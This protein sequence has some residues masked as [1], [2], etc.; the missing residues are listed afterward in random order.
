MIDLSQNPFY[1]SPD[2]IK[3]VNETKNS[4]SLEEKVG[5]LF[6]VAA[7]IPDKEMIEK[8]ISGIKPGGIMFRPLPGNQVREL[9]ELVNSISTVPMLVA[10]NLEDGASGIS[11]D[12]VRFGNNMQVAATGD[13]EFA[14]KQGI[15][16]GTQGASVGCNWSFSPVVDLNINHKNPITNTRSYGDKTEVV[17]EMSCSFVKGIQESGIAATIKHFPGDGVDDRDHH[18]LTSCNNLTKEQW[19]KTYGEVYKSLIKVGTKAVMAGHISL[20]CYQS[21]VLPATL[22]S[23]LLVDLLR[24]QLGFNGV[25]VTDATLM[26]GFAVEERAKTVPKSIAAGCDMFLFTRNP[27]EDFNAMMMGVMEGVI[28]Q[29]RLDEAVTRVLALKASQKLYVNEKVLIPDNE[30]INHWHKACVDKAVTLLKD[31]QGVIPL[32]PKVTQKIQ[33]RKLYNAEVP[34]SEQAVES[35]REKLISK[36]FQ[37]GILDGEKAS[38]MLMFQSV[39]EF[40]SQYDM[41]IYI[42]DLAPKSNRTTLRFS[43]GSQYGVDFPVM[44]HEIPMISVNFGSPYVL[45]DLPMMKTVINAYGNQESTIEAVVNKLVGI[46]EFTGLS[47]VEAI[48]E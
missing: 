39:E 33:L 7:A 8:F 9:T 47:P 22:S 32:N 11:E 24:N 28:S 26:V 4:L 19:D 16:A 6:C 29:Q 42:S 3:W 46:G 43:Y 25:I 18:L 13:S 41:V 35:F 30:K 48:F 10:A 37:V 17:K 36:G 23:E 45:Y 44:V 5:Q 1:L 21:E 38:P 31:T 20:P 12:F 27:M 15:S 40:K 34:C 2:E 14:Y